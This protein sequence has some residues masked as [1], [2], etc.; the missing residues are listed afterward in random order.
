ML[1]SHVTQSTRA[2]AEADIHLE[3]SDLKFHSSMWITCNHLCSSLIRFSRL[4]KKKLWYSSFDYFD[5]CH[6]I[7]GLTSKSPHERVVALADVSDAIY[8]LSLPYLFFFIFWGGY[9]PPPR[10]RGCGQDSRRCAAQCAIVDH[11]CRIKVRKKQRYTAG[12]RNSRKLAMDA[13]LMTN[14]STYS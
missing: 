6:A 3:L 2:P 7:V 14:T 13:E 11:D 8:F 5:L 9:P 10:L 12:Q 4:L 1:T